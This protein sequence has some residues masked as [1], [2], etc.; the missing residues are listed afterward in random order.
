ML[1]HD[2]RHHVGIGAN[3]PG[4]RAAVLRGFSPCGKARARCSIGTAQAFFFPCS[5][6]A[7]RLDCKSRAC[8]VRLKT[9]PILMIR[10][11]Q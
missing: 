9:K 2:A 11:N 1:A 10:P 3:A 7:D 5:S 8:P 4:R 6:R